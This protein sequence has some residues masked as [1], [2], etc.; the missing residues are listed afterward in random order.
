M[1][2][3]AMGPFTTATSDEQFDPES[4]FYNFGWTQ[5]QFF[6]IHLSIYSYE[7]IFNSIP[8]Q[9]FINVSISFCVNRYSW[10][11]HLKTTYAYLCLL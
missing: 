11:T 1:M 7:N 3:A 2:E 6:P 9:G 4:L 8:S 10:Q 5:K